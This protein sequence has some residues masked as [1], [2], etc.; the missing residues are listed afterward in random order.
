MLSI[1]NLVGEEELLTDFKTL[2]RNRKVNGEKMLTLSAFPTANNVHAFPLIEEES[3]VTFKDEEY[4]IKKFGA[5]SIGNR[6]TKQVEAI[7]KFFPDMLDKRQRKIHNGSMT[8]AAACQFVFEDSGYTFA[9]I[10]TFTAKQ[11]ENFGGNNRLALLQTL[12]DRYEAEMEIVGK[13]VRF[14]KKIGVDTDFQFRYGHN[15]KTFSRDVDTSNLSTYIEGKGAEGITANYTSPNAGIF[16]LRDAEDVEDERFT[17]E[18][19][20][21]A[22][23]KKRLVDTPE[24][25]L[26]VDF[27]DL[28]AAGY[29]YPVP[30]EGDRVFV[31]FE[32]MDDLEVETRQ[33]EIVEDFN[34]NLEPIS[35]K[36]TLANHS[37]TYS[38]TMFSNVQK[39]LKVIVNDDGMIKYNVLDEAVRLA[40]EAIQSAQ[41][42]LLFNNGI[43]GI[44]KEDPNLLTR[45]TSR[46]IGVSEDGGNTFPEAITGRGV[47]TSLLTAGGIHTNN[48]AIIGDSLFFWDGSG[49]HAIDPADLDKFVRILGGEI[50][51]SKGAMTLE[52]PD[53]YKVINN[54]MSVYDVNI[55]AITKPMFHGPGV[56]DVQ[57]GYSVWMKSRSTTSLDYNQYRFKH[58]GRYLKVRFRLLA[59]G[60][61]KAHLEIWRGGS[62]VASAFTS[63]TDEYDPSVLIGSTL[64]VDLGVPD[65]QRDTFQI[66]MRSSVSDA[67]VFAI[68]TDY[69][70][71]G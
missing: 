41:T 71:E 44:D 53:G 55:Q 29:P 28:R 9:I 61:N 1:R 13:Q 33:M 64:T 35:T 69:W 7:H 46:G 60:S 56:V 68:V 49:F 21:R 25:S 42:E 16:G 14:K 17:S 6:F 52:R 70:Q 58:D 66:R 27:V 67:D 31:I 45:F 24:V 2:S 50:Y 48:I 22:E 39:A 51:I 47:N 15:I 23:L 57:K 65:G 11:F 63:V 34:V 20:L 40:T 38:G 54:G 26:T 8:F 4:V 59:G 36:V 3:V 19:T 30:N 18:P 5:R 43:T 12:L 62:L 37:K 32:P 10:D